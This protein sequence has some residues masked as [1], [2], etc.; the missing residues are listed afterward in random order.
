LRI[1]R[2]HREAAH[3]TNRLIGRFFA[4]MAIWTVVFGGIL[5]GHYLLQWW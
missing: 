4:G 5:A 3:A 2:T 1:F